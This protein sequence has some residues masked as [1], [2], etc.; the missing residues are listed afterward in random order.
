VKSRHPSPHQAARKIEPSLKHML[1]HLA[2]PLRV[3]KLSALSGV[4]NSYFFSL[5]KSATGRA[6]IDFFIHLRMRRACELLRDRKLNI[7]E[8]AFLLGYDDP[9]YFSRLF[10]S[11][12]GMAPRQYRGQ[13]AELKFAK[14]REDLTEVLSNFPSAQYLLQETTKPTCS[15]TT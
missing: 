14:P 4:S 9:F 7:K 5:F 13:S 2:E 3:S 12:I 11:V 10:K 15:L 6:P 1:E 8:V